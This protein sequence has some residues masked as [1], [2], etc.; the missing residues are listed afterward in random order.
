MAELLPA[1]SLKQQPGEAQPTRPSGADAGWKGAGLWMAYLDFSTDWHLCSSLVLG[2]VLTQQR[3]KR[4]LHQRAQPP[5]RSGELGQRQ[6]QQQQEDAP[7][8][9]DPP[10]VS[11]AGSCRPQLYPKRSWGSP[12]KTHWFLPLSKEAQHVLLAPDHMIAWSGQ[13]KGS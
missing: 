7:G 9:R 10:A 6:R 13:V 2:L 5:S 11:R 1:P 4:R 8:S 12:L 3:P